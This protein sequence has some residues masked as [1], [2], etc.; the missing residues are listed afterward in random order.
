MVA[1]LDITDHE[2]SRKLLTLHTA[3]TVDPMCLHVVRFMHTCHQLVEVA[4]VQSYMGGLRR[5]HS[6]PMESSEAL[7]MEAARQN[8]MTKARIPLI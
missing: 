5:S 7:M 1:E 8:I 2:A 4:N 3:I 6:K